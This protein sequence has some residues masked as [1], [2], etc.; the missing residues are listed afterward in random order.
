VAPPQVKIFWTTRAS[1]Q[2]HAAFDYWSTQHF[3][4]ASGSMM[5]RIFSAVEVLATYPEAGRRGRIPGTREIVILRTPFVIAYR[6]Q[7]NE[8]QILAVLHGARKW[9]ERF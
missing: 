9:P 3:P 5:N 4:E 6:V 7:R 8:I 1:Q 2:L